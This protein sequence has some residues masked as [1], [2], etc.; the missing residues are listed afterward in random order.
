MYIKTN[1]VNM[2]NGALEEKK[3]WKPLDLETVTRSFLPLALSTNLPHFVGSHLG[4][5]RFV[6]RSTLQ[7]AS[8]GLPADLMGTVFR[9]G[10]WK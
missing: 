8:T 4:H 10:P 2:C 7:C 5:C 3:L 6:D 1:K 9:G